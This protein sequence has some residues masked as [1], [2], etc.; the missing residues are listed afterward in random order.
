MLWGRG[1]SK[2]PTTEQVRQSGSA[3]IVAGPA[4]RAWTNSLQG[5]DVTSSDVEQVWQA[6]EAQVARRDPLDLTVH[7][8]PTSLAAWTARASLAIV[9]GMATLWTFTLL[10]RV[11]DSTALTVALSMPLAVGSGSS[12]ASGC[13][14]RCAGQPGHAPASWSDFHWHW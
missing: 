5:A 12:L 11:T 13:Q 2:W 3:V 9:V 1:L 6:I 14:H 4:L 10:L 8:L 7:P